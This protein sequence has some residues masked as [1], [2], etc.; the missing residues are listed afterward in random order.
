[1]ANTQIL[2]TVIEPELAGL[3]LLDHAAQRLQIGPVLGMDCDLIAFSES[4]HI[5]WF[6]EITA[7]GFLGR[8]DKDFHVG[9]VRKF[10][11]GF[12]KFSL[13]RHYELKVRQI[14]AATYPAVC[15]AEMRCQFVVPK[16]SRFIRALGWR[17]QLLDT[18]VMSI[19][20]IKLSEASEVVMKDAL[21]RA[22]AEQSPSTPAMQ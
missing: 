20:E 19:E 11:E 5:L 22:R 21:L 16:G 3:F 10:C 18:G 9:A 13:I 12:S 1:M 15:A 6:C 14:V 7:S 8:Q 2:K 4:N 17:Q